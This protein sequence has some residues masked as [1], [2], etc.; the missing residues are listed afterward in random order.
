MFMK[1]ECLKS[2]FPS[3]LNL[4]TQ[5]YIVLSPSMC[6]PPLMSLVTADVVVMEDL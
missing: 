1:S 2:T 4:Q 5:Q 3:N 6:S